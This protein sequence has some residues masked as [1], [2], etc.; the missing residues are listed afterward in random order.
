MTLYVLCG[1]PASGKTTLSHILTK[2][3]NAKLYCYDD[4]KLKHLDLYERIKKDLPTHNVVLDDL[5][6]V[7]AWRKELLD[8]IK[9]V[10]CKKV[11]IVLTTPLDVCIERNTIRN[12]R[13]S[14]A[15]I[16]HL[17]HRYQPPTLDEG[18]DDIQYI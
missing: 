10:N 8:S 7:K 2:K 14:N 12:S 11:L 16:Y 17:S 4:H 13:P 18:W 1:L 3:Y 5:M 15:A 6:L 9:E